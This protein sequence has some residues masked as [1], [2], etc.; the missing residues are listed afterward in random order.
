MKQPPDK[1]WHQHKLW[2]WIIK[3]LIVALL[4]WTV[5]KQVF[6]KENI[7]QIWLVLVARFTQEHIH[8][9]I[10]TTLLIPVNWGLE[11]LKWQQLIKTFSN[12][13]FWHIYK[14][15]LAGIAIGLFTPNRIGEYGGRILLV[16]PE[17]NWKAVI[18]TAVGG[19]SQLL[20][21]LAFG[22]LGT[23]YFASLYLMLD[24]YLLYLLLFIG[25][26]LI[27]LMMFC[28]FNIDLLIPV[29]KRLPYIH[30]LK[31]Y[32]KH[33]A[34]LTSY[35]SRELWKALTYSTLRFFTYAAQYYFMLQFFGI[36][37]P[38]IWIGFAGVFTH[39][40]L[41]T[42]I[43]LPPVMDVFARGPMALFVWS[44]FSEDQIGILGSTYTLYL[45]NL[46]FPAILGSIFILKVNIIKSLGYNSVN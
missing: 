28:F 21:L 6:D 35:S 40:F 25:V 4:F 19:F 36:E 38:S 29:A 1:K 45:I 23:I 33:L 34:V 32:F 9:L 2:N 14:A 16:A 42:A 17:H 12:Y 7:S 22:L 15:I 18:A 27:T 8:W 11:A 31:K 20:V 43:P 37:I 39:Y 26:G 24:P 3:M 30:L 5:Y 10:L 44:R 41:Q 46:I 13:T